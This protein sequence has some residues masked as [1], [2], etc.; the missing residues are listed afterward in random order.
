MQLSCIHCGHAFSI[1]TEQLGG[2]GHCPH[3]GG[4]IHLPKTGNLEAS[5]EPEPVRYRRWWEGSISGLVSVV[6]H[7]LLFIILALVSY[8]SYSGEG[9]GE[10]VLIGEL[11][12]ENLGET[13]EDELNTEVTTASASA[14]AFEE[15]L[16]VEPPVATASESFESAELALASPSS[17]GGPSGSMEF[18]TITSGGGTMGGGSWNGLLQ[19]LRRNG[20][21]IVITFDSTGS[22]DGEIRQVKEQISRIGGALLKLVPKARIGLC[23]YRDQGEE[24]VVR[25][26]PLTN[27]IQEVQEFLAHVEADGGGDAPEAVQEG[28]QWS[29]QQNQFRSGARNV[30]LIFG[31]APPHSDDRDECLR[32]ASDF[33]RQHKGI[34][35]TVTCRRRSPLPEFTEIA[36]V[37]GGESFLTTD[38]REIMTQLLVLVFGSS[39]RSKVLEAF[40]LLEG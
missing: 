28:L 2:R 11:P 8:N 30:I 9:L 14:E 26:I 39:H 3:C 33:H 32:L 23:T 5:P 21:D 6:L 19:N 25:G 17:G 35:S 20:L 34:I 1:T 38:E 29:L 16:E 12:S 27:N 13:Q 18:G 31:D 36:E 7:M 40:K 22:M 24:Y 37:A 4:L 10:D 15:M